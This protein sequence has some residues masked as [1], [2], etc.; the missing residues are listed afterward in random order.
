MYAQLSQHSHN[1]NMEPAGYISKP[2]SQVYTATGKISIPIFRPL[3]GIP[4]ATMLAHECSSPNDYRMG[5]TSYKI[6]HT[7][8][9]DKAI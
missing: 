2:T 3:I 5:T 6:S 4:V 1:E 7:S 8:Q 9:I